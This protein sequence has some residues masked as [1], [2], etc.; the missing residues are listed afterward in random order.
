MQGK[1]AALSWSIIHSL[2][3]T[4]EE[5][6]LLKFNESQ[7][8]FWM[9]LVTGIVTVIISL[10][11]G[12]EITPLSFFIL[13]LYSLAV[14]GGDFCYV[15]AIQT[16]PIG[17]ANLID[18]GNLFL[19]LICD[20]ALGYIKPKISFL[21][22]FLIF[23]ISIYVFSNETNKMKEEIPNKKID[24]KN[25]FIL[26]TS[27]IFYASEPYFIKLA[28]SKGANEYGINLVYFLIAIPFFYILYHHEKKHIPKLKKIEKKSFT[29]NIILI[30]IIYAITSLLYMLAFI[31]ETPILITLITK[32]QLFFVV[33]ISVVRKT[34][35]MNV[36]KTISLI[37]GVLCLILMTILT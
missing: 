25:I 6:I 30:G 7:Y 5:E 18:S 13:I 17:L 27:T 33:I 36:K 9:T 31:G 32:L 26:I 35:K 10:I 21:I 15:K 2:A 23:F 8:L 34:D 14:I 4:I 16:V 20:I 29:K 11:G 22:L 1:K 24:L 37:T 19:I 12:I 3:D 28:N